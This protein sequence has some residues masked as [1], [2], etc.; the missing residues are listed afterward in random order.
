VLFGAAS[1]WIVLWW[2]GVNVVKRHQSG[3]VEHRERRAYRKAGPD[4]C[5]EGDGLSIRRPGKPT[6]VGYIFEG[7]DKG[8]GR[9]DVLESQLPNVVME[10]RTQQRY[11]EILPEL[12]KGLGEKNPNAVPRIDRVVVNVGVGKYPQGGEPSQGNS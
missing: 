6:R 8:A 11:I 3:E 7:K 2:R 5:F 1:G 12:A 4:P 9:Q 10:P